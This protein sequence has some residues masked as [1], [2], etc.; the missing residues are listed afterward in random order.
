MIAGLGSIISPARTHSCQ[1]SM[2]FA[3][4][5]P[6]LT[7]RFR[8]NG[9][10]SARVADRGVEVLIVAGVVY[11]SFQFWSGMPFH[12]AAADAR[13]ISSLTWQTGPDL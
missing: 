5:P 3:A 2:T 8:A 7:T 9:S 1:S 10:H 13:S 6:R 12:P 11:V 4:Y